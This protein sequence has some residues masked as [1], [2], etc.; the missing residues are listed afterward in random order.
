MEK[1][2]AIGHWA[3]GS[4]VFAV[5]DAGKDRGIW[6]SNGLDPE[7]IFK[8][9]RSPNVAADLKEQVASGIKIGISVAAVAV[10][11]RASGV[12][13]KIVA[14]YISEVGAG[15]IY[16]K[17]DAAINA[18]KDLDGKK[19]GV[20]STAHATYR[21]TLWLSNKFAIKPQFVP[22]GN[23][24]SML[25]ALKFGK[26][27]AFVPN[28]PLPLR[29]VDSGELSILIRLADFLPKP[30]LV[31]VLFA[32]EDLIEQNP[33]LIR[34]FV[35]ATLE[36]VKYL[37]EN[38]RYTSELFMKKTNAPLD[39]ADRIMSS[40]VWTP[41]GRG[42]GQDLTRAAANVWQFHKESAGLPSGINL[43]MKIE[44]AVDVRFL[45]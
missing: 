22:L 45:P 29:L 26:I 23:T 3:D 20:I 38:P 17:P 8:P 35:K 18:I 15:N 16:V 44:D 7:F 6:A 42:S 14:G 37:K 25:V 33:D 39:I 41:S 2:K 1:F 10:Q 4:S 11:A 40:T 21:S 30:W 9:D 19:V 5:I 43:N 12:P 36:T 31:N 34:R 28:D 13:L 27:D 32:T 24:T